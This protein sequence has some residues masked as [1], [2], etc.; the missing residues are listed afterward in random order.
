ME[1]LFYKKKTAILMIAAIIV[2]VFLLC[3]LLITLTQLT[4]LNQK[5][6]KLELLVKQAEE[7]QAAKE[8]LIQYRQT[9]KYVIDWAIK[10]N[11]IPDDVINYIQNNTDN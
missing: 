4:S 2:L 8:E 7:D 9:D 3:M 5:V 1:K 11:L 10:M 6:E